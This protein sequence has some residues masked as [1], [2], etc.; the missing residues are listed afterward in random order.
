[1]IQLC[2]NNS[3]IAVLIC[4]L[5]INASQAG[6]IGA[7]KCLYNFNS[8]K[9]SGVFTNNKSFNSILIGFSEQDDTFIPNTVS[10]AG[11]DRTRLLIASSTML[12][13]YSTAFVLLHRMW[14]KNYP[15][16]S[17]HF[18]ND[19]L[20]WLQMD[21]AGHAMSSYYLS[22]LSYKTFLWTGMD[23]RKATLWGSLSGWAF[24][25]TIEVFDGFSA[26][27]GASIGDLIANTLGAAMFTSQQ[28]I[29]EEQ[30]VK[31][32]FSFR[33]SGLETY[34]PDLLGSNLPENILKDYNGQ[35]YWLSFNINSISNTDFTP[36]WLNIALGYG[37][38][39]MLGSRSNPSHY[40]G[41]ALPHYE[42]TRHY[43]IAPDIDWSRIKTNSA[44]LQ[45]TFSVLDFLKLPAPALEYS[46]E[47]GFMFHF[48][49]F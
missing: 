16:S 31:M 25:S 24:I 44:F 40:N 12:A 2:K 26:Q 49:F 27:W 48:I 8:D 33:Q 46:K 20:D 21:K 29:W 4:L 11:T 23:N 35:T 15:H 3:A 10:L 6:N 37:A 13:G 18:H 30:K 36:D 17:F 22:S 42:R 34:R 39:G 43:Y 14:Y 38:Y 5:F 45:T 1:M 19:N 28:L 32:K 7:E 47:H 9:A 41:Q